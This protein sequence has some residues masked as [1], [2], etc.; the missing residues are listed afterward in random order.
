MSVVTTL[1]SS[2]NTSLSLLCQRQLLVRG[3]DIATLRKYAGDFL[4][5]AL[6]DKAEDYRYRRP[7]LSVVGSKFEVVVIAA[8]YDVPNEVGLRA[9]ESAGV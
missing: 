2:A 8:C 7:K 1:C 9:H 5:G 4:Y 3:I 6:Q